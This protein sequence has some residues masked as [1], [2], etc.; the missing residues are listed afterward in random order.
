MIPIE[1]AERNR[2][3]LTPRGMHV[4]VTGDGP[5]PGSFTVETEQ[6][7]S[8]VMEAG[9][10]LRTEATIAEVAAPPQGGGT[11]FEKAVAAAGAKKPD[12]LGALLQELTDDDLTALL[13]RHPVLWVVGAVQRE[14][15]RRAGS[16]VEELLAEE[17]KEAPITCPACGNVAQA[18]ERSG[19]WIVVT[20][21][22]HDAPVCPGS[23]RAVDVATGSAP[24]PGR[25]GQEIHAQIRELDTLGAVEAFRAELENPTKGAIE[26][27]D[28]QARLLTEGAA[29]HERA[30]AGDEDAIGL[31]AS[32]TWASRAQIAIRGGVRRAFGTAAVWAGEEIRRIQEEKEVDRATA[33]AARRAAERIAG[34]DPQRVDRALAE[35]AEDPAIRARVDALKAGVRG[36]R[37]AARIELD[38]QVVERA[39]AEELAGE[40]RP[41]IVGIL[42][43]RA[44]ALRGET[45]RHARAKRT[46]AE[47]VED[48]MAQEDAAAEL[49]KARAELAER[50]KLL[51]DEDAIEA[52]RAV[53]ADPNAPEELKGDAR[54]IARLRL[55]LADAARAALDAAPVHEDPPILED[56]TIE[57]FGP[58]IQ[59]VSPG[60]QEKI[61]EIAAE[62][63]EARQPER[64]NH[65]GIRDAARKLAQLPAA[66][67]RRRIPLSSLGRA[68][69]L[70]ALCKPEELPELQAVLL[71]REEPVENRPR[72]RLAIQD[73]IAEIEEATRT[74]PTKASSAPQGAPEVQE[75]PEAPVEAPEAPPRPRPAPR[76][77]VPEGTQRLVLR[78]DPE[79]ETLWAD[80]G[81]GRDLHRIGFASD[82]ELRELAAAVRRASLP[83]A[84]GDAGM[85]E[86]LRKAQ[87]DAEARGWRPE[88]EPAPSTG[89][90]KLAH[91]LHAL[92]EALPEARA[93]GIRLTLTI[94]TKEA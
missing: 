26:D 62:I 65:A 49:V 78:E 12:E 90:Q 11:A 2:W 79:G 86:R 16:A 85:A 75:A 76:P 18:R 40:N 33:E 83:Q 43:A 37:E 69:E 59:K 67:L 39:L 74:R 88:I 46:T 36:A 94:D 14:R 6:G 41:T 55:E 82:P 68:L 64:V 80:F 20:H 71:G 25:T 9:Q 92:A 17:T 5:A 54:A 61:E 7:R 73:R 3:Y 8:F 4:R 58:P 31:L 93:L 81:P 42:E 10:V 38:P 29:V 30:K 87:A 51:T 1:Q 72:V 89:T 27:L 35:G 53:V 70:V 19:R 47:E 50:V 24:A 57:G 32:W 84:L 66:P 34:E 22:A 28:T 45:R 15:E 44:A 60:A 91:A 48:G 23:G 21:P 52:C 56:G 13:S 63:E 77:L